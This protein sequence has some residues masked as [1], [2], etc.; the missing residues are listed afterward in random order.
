[1]SLC[2][3]TGIKS[4][5]AIAETQ[6]S[7]KLLR[8]CKLPLANKQKTGETDQK[9]RGA[10]CTVFAVQY[11]AVAFR[12]ATR[13]DRIAVWQGLQHFQTAVFDLWFRLSG[14]EKTL[15]FI[16]ALPVLF[17]LANKSES[18]TLIAVSGLIALILVAYLVIFVLSKS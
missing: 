13:H 11:R 7:C 17:Y 12:A 3:R 15:V 14:S 16:L 9:E 10:R 5:D 18:N 1:M 2:S 8:S 4:A 6:I